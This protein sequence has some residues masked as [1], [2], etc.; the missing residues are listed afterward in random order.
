MSLATELLTK[1]DGF[2][3]EH[4]LLILGAAKKQHGSEL[5]LVR[6]FK[7]PMRNAGCTKPDKRYMDRRQSFPHDMTVTTPAIPTSLVYT[8]ISAVY[9]SPPALA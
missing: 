5:I 1:F 8:G 4:S 6:A 7:T 3:D 2:S 9:C